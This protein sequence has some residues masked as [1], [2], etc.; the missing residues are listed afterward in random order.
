MCP[1]P[2]TLKFNR[3]LEDVEIDLRAKIHQAKCSGSWVIVVTEKKTT[4]KTIQSVATAR[5]G[6]IYRCSRVICVRWAAVVQAYHRACT[7]PSKPFLLGTTVAG[8]SAES[9][10]S[11]RWV[12]GW[13]GSALTESDWELCR[14]SQQKP[15]YTTQCT[16]PISTVNPVLSRAPE[17]KFFD[18][19]V[20]RLSKF[21]HA[22]LSPNKLRQAPK[23]K[24]PNSNIIMQPCPDLYRRTGFGS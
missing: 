16:T 11:R 12:C 13:L 2:M 10:V 18:I 20:S 24:T 6:T 19:V 9:V 22:C 7:R 21:L 23:W 1:W 15:H 5:T 17:T 8:D 3:V 14:S 4:T